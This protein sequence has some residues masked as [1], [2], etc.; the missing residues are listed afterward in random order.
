M[1][2]CVLLSKELEKYR[3]VITKKKNKTQKTHSSNHKYSIE[4]FGLKIE[5]IEK[6]KLPF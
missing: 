2:Y 3:D 1:L 6:I 5:D 4:E